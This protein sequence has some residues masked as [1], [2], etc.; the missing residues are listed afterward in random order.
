MKIEQIYTGCL[1]Q[2]AYYIE[3]EGE[4][5]VIDPLREIS[6]YLDRAA[7]DNAQI[8]FVFETHFHADFVSGHLD[9]SKKTGA[10]IVYGPNAN[11]SFDCHIA[12]DGEEFKIGKLRL[13]VL[14][15]PGHTMES[16]CY[17]LFDE[18]GHEKALFSGDTLFI[19]DVGRPDL[20]QKAA[21]LTE[22]QLAETLFD[23]LRQKVMTLPDEVVVYPA[24]GAGSAC[25]KN[26]SKETFD[27]LGHQKLVNYAL[28]ADMTKAEFVR[29]VTDGLLAPPAYFPLNVALNK[30]GS[31]PLDEV[32]AR[33]N[34]PLSPRAF[35][36]AANETNALILDTR[37]PQ[38]FSEAF[39]PNSI[40]IGIDG[41]FAPWVGSLIPDL[42]QQ[43]LIVAAPGREPEV[44]TRLARVGYDYCLGFLDGGLDAWKNAGFETDSIDRVSAAELAEILK[45][46]VA[47]PV[48]DVRKP[49]EF[50]A[51][52]LEIADLAPL[53]FLH[54]S[55]SKIPKDGPVYLHCAGG[56]RS[57][58]FASILRARG[59]RN[60][61][62]VK[63]GYAALQKSGLF[64]TTDFT[65]KLSDGVMK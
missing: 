57:M 65:C 43:L 54:E 21:D 29:E 33:G 22:Q 59:W 37:D 62:D 23:S 19:G 13:R 49:G 18:N 25:G 32:M 46:E 4:A 7:K 15:T 39:I 64:A 11:P 24:H 10:T 9:L 26:M 58:I 35:E 41:S 36:A 3:S 52:H 5:V 8:R 63:G 28:R 40:N 34:R 47:A 12:A 30:R 56:Y 42:R 20:A 17:L 1:A 31:D 2:G 6:A 53:D 14:H 45:K 48:F 38:Q 16:T 55:M 60:L 51:E 27:S 44:I 61:I 50:E